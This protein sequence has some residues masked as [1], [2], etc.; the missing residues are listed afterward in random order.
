M[1]QQLND[2]T[3]ALNTTLLRAAEKFKALGARGRVSLGPGKQLSVR[4]GQFFID[5]VPK[6]QR[7]YSVPLLKAS[8]KERIE[9]AQAL[10]TLWEQCGGAVRSSEG[11]PA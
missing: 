5:Y 7:S 4:E 10:P 11:E 6:G 9:A 3:D 2:A 1:A 8:R